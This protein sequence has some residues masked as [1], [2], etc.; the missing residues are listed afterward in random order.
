[1]S[2]YL[3]G[4]LFLLANSYDEPQRLNQKGYSLY[5]SFRPEGG[6]WGL[7]GDLKLAT[8]LKLRLQEEP[9]PDTLINKDGTN[10]KEDEKAAEGKDDA[11][12]KDEK[13][14]GVAAFEEFEAMEGAEDFTIWDLYE[15]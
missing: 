6:G 7:R 5:C 9:S 4:A 3:L 11:G 15:D 8:I 12:K 10:I 13:I 2:P 1:M 14:D